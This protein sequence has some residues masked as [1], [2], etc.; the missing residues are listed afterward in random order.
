MNICLG[1]ALTIS[2]TVPAVVI[3]WL[4]GIDVILGL[5][6]T[7]IVLLVLTLVLPLVTFGGQRTNM[8]QGAV[9]SVVFF[10]FLVVI[11]DT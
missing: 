1:S 10:A 6:P 5:E 2:L 11:F 4:A 3:A 7:E 9:H 8:L